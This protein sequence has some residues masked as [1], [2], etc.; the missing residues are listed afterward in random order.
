MRKAKTRKISAVRRKWAPKSSGVW[1][2][3][4]S[5]STVFPIQATYGVL[6][7]I[8]FFCN[9]N[10]RLRNLSVEKPTRQPLSPHS[11]KDTARGVPSRAHRFERLFGYVA[12]LIIRRSSVSRAWH[13]RVDAC[14]CSDE[15]AGCFAFDRGFA[16][17]FARL[18]LPLHPR[19]RRSNTHDGVFPHRT[20]PP[21]EGR[22]YVSNARLGD[23]G[24]FSSLRPVDF[25]PETRTRYGVRSVRLVYARGR[26]RRATRHEARLQRATPLTSPFPTRIIHRASQ[27]PLP[28]PAAPCAGPPPRRW[29]RSRSS[30]RCPWAR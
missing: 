6:V 29:A 2:I 25:P 14:D 26:R 28:P 15:S 5:L 16:S 10:P 20:H 13:H 18:T 22:G 1:V 23:R 30:P 21:A 8:T 19:P 3:D 27:L 24:R 12:R 9:T 11:R 7:R 17:S 4:Q